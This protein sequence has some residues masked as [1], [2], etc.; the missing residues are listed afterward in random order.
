MTKCILIKFQILPKYILASRATRTVRQRSRW[1][2]INSRSV[3][4]RSC[5]RC[6]SW[7]HIVW[8]LGCFQSLFPQTLSTFY[9]IIRIQ[10]FDACIIFL[11]VG[12]N[13]RIQIHF[14]KLIFMFD[15]IITFIPIFIPDRCRIASIILRLF[16]SK[17]SLNSQFADFICATLEFI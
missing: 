12:R 13:Q 8:F 9:N 7:W 6:V 11:W 5:L 1:R 15:V 10:C 16:M 4:L 3:F 17:H 2:M 14:S